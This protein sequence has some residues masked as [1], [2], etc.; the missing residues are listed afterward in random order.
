MAT[1]RRFLFA[2]LKAGGP[3]FEIVE[4]DLGN[5]ILEGHI[6]EDI[7]SPG[8]SQLVVHDTSGNVKGLSVPAGSVIGKK[9]GAAEISTL[10]DTELHTLLNVENG[11]ESNSASN[12]EADDA[13][14]NNIGLFYQKAGSDLRFRTLIPKK[15]HTS[16][17]GWERHGRVKIEVSSGINVALDPLALPHA[18]TI[19]DPAVLNPAGGSLLLPIFKAQQPV[20]IT[21]GYGIVSRNVDTEETGIKVKLHN[22]TTVDTVGATQMAAS[23]ILNSKDGTEGGNVNSTIALSAT[24]TDLEIAADSWAFLEIEGPFDGDGTAGTDTVYS[25]HLTLNFELT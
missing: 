25:L 18:M 17:A 22:N 1:K 24:K 15:A 14:A 10:V 9:T 16:G 7:F 3:E 5:D 4:Q 23:I 6:N 2:Q 20:A 13:V 8:T 12:T 11:S 21:S 19:T